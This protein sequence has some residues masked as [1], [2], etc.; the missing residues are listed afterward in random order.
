MGGAETLIFS[1]VSKTSRKGN[2]TE[3]MKNRIRGEVKKV[4]K[5]RK[6]ERK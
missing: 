1:P 3:M 4:R 2:R 6:K 5:G